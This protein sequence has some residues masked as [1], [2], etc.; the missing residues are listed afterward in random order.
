MCGIAGILNYERGRAVPE[1]VIR[2]MV[3]ALHHRGPDAEGVQI[4]GNVGLGFARLAILDL[5]PA[6]H[7]PMTTEDGTVWSTVNGEIYNFAALARDLRARGH[8]LRSRSDSEV[9][10]HLYEEYGLDFIHRLEGM[11]ALALWDSRQ[12][13]LVL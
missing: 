7:Q 9:V 11:F 3:R 10:G 8:Q 4:D 12:Q 13:R 6:G 5:T 2:R 1:A